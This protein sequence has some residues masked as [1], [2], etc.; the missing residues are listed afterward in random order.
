MPAS[1]RSVPKDLPSRQL[2]EQLRG[3]LAGADKVVGDIC[4]PP[5]MP[6]TT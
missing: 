5:P 3:E 1:L 4:D 2:A 6:P